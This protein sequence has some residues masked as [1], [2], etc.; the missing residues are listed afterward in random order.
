GGEV[1]PGSEATGAGEG[2][3]PAG[4]QHN[5][6]RLVT[7]TVATTHVL[8]PHPA[9]FLDGVRLDELLDA[10]RPDYHLLG[11]IPALLDFLSDPKERELVWRRIR[12]PVGESAI[13]PV[14]ICPDDC[15]LWCSVVVAEVVADEAVIHWMRLGLDMT[16]PEPGEM[17]D[18]VG[19][20]VEW[21]DGLGPYRFPRAEYERSL[22]A[23]A[24]CPGW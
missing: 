14:L 3:D 17:P 19:R 13:A 1:D 5:M 8:E 6:N 12:P 7:N 20:T 9:L 23:F 10:A 22:A 2:A 18:V 4:L 24:L 11:L 15:D 16:K 21:F